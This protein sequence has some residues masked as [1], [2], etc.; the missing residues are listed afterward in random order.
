ME[1]QRLN[2]NLQRT[3]KRISNKTNKTYVKKSTKGGQMHFT[4]PILVVTPIWMKQITKQ[5]GKT[6]VFGRF[7]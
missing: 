5:I 1:D 4:D 3:M 6:K 2:H 7:R